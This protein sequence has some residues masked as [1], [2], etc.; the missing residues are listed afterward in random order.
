[1]KALLI[2]EQ[3]RRDLRRIKLA[4]KP[5]VND[6][7]SLQFALE[8]LQT[9]ASL[10]AGFRDHALLREYANYREFHLDADWLVIYRVHED[11]IVLHRTGTHRDLF[12]RWRSPSSGR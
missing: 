10:P 9:D 8:L 4:R 1:V 2:T 6:W 5:T 12:Q 3:F 7:E 11:R